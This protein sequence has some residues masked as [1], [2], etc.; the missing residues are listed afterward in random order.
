[1]NRA[2]REVMLSN[3]DV[4]S[5]TMLAFVRLCVS[6]L[7]MYGQIDA[8]HLRGH[9]HP[10]CRTPP[11]PCFQHMITTSKAS[12]P[13]ML[14]QVGRWR[15]ADCLLMWSAAFG[16][17]APCVLQQITDSMALS[18]YIRHPLMVSS[19]GSRSNWSLPL[20]IRQSRL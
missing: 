13:E 20:A 8:T 14:A 12:R 18:P 17:A 1:M 15:Y 6:S 5:V 19:S 11:L 9:L 2:Y 16:D 4:L 10:Q 3:G 7:K